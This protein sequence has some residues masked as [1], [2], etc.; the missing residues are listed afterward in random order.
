MDLVRGRAR[1]D[2]SWRGR[3]DPLLLAR[4]EALAAVPRT[5]VGDV[6]A[7]HAYF[8]GASAIVTGGASG[9]GR[10]LGAQ[11]V[12]YGAHVVLADIDRDAVEQAA[13]ELARDSG[14]GSVVGRSLDVQDCAGV[15][16]LVEAVCA[17]TRACRPD[18]QQRR[19]RIGRTNRGDVG[20]LLGSNS[21]GQRWWRHQWNLGRLPGDGCPRPRSHRE[22]WIRCRAG[23][24][25]VRSRVLGDQ[26][27][28]CGAEHSVAIRG[29][30]PRGPG[31]CAVPGNGRDTDSRQG[32]TYGSPA[33]WR[34]AADRTRVSRDRWSVTDARG[35]L[36]PP[37]P[38]GSG[39][40]ERSSLCPARSVPGGISLGSRRDSS[41]P[42]AASLRAGF[43]GRWPSRRS[44]RGC[45]NFC[46]RVRAD[47][48][49]C[50]WKEE[51]IRSTVRCRMR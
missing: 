51:R 48:L 49:P 42:S 33:T 15:R 7:N 6:R 5:S 37:G 32:S 3:P 17:R 24:C 25:A 50:S 19:H 1:P 11:L 10:A 4:L 38:A 30:G 20:C 34:I 9:I 36:R 8:E 29:R 43:A 35:A 16:I 39:R 2:R 14:S 27:R 28:G 44:R 18:V 12:S 45:T 21:R 41:T 46:R 26:A 13:A 22:H 31:E 23:V 47:R 40:T